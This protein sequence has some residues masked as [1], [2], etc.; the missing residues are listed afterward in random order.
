MPRP[1]KTN[2]DYFPLYCCYD[3]R[4]ALAEAEQ[5]IEAF[6]VYIKLL[7]RI[8][9][10]KGY[11]LVWEK[12]NELLFAKENHIDYD[13]VRNVVQTL[14][15]YGFFDEDIFR[16]YGILTSK[17]IQEHYFYAVSR[18]KLDDLDE[19]I[20]L[21]NVTETKVNVAETPAKAAEIPVQPAL[22]TQIIENKIKENK[23]IEKESGVKASPT[24]APAPKKRGRMS[25]VMLTDSEYEQLKASY[26]D[27][28]S[29]ID[30]LSVYMAS[31]GKNYS[32][33]HATLIRWAEEDT[34]RGSIAPVYKGYAPK[35]QTNTKAASPKR[36]SS[37]DIDEFYEYAL[38][39]DIRACLT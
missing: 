32:S 30:R 3:E 33:H 16:R 37:F 34:A 39:Q 10:G 26:P 20:I 1:K 27:I 18:R 28:D 9:G 5:G 24:P 21:V 25:N 36:E 11:Y 23:I 13:K 35:T 6:Y 29:I 14:I 12:K 22:S 2:I 15:E 7:M 17:E 4:I 19:R 8:Y 38:K 31:T